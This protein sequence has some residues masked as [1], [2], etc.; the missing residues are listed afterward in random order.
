MSGGRNPEHC[1]HYALAAGT[2]LL[3]LKLPYAPVCAPAEPR[4]DA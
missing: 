4:G 2:Q 1:G 3:S